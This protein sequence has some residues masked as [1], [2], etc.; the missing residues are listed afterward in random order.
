MVVW[1]HDG[2]QCIV[3]SPLWSRGWLGAVVWDSCPDHQRVSYAI[4]LAIEKMKIKI[5][6][7]VSSEYVYGFHTILKSKN[8]KLQVGDTHT[9]AERHM[10]VCLHESREKWKII[11]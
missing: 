5:Q 11:Y 6:S 1:V 2:C 3:C 4:P 10:F 7:T 8:H 9:N